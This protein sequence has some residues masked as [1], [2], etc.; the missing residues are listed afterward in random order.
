M[1]TPGWSFTPR[2]RDCLPKT[3]PADEPGISWF[4]DAYYHQ[5]L[6]EGAPLPEHIDL[7]MRSLELEP[8]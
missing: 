4:L 3:F 8:S 1:Q 6:P 7:A 5:E 2:D